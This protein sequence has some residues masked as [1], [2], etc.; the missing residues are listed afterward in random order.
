MSLSH[1]NYSSALLFCSQSAAVAAAAVSSCWISPG[2]GA[3]IR[4]CCPAGQ[5][6]QQNAKAGCCISGAPICCPQGWQPCGA[7]LAFS[8]SSWCCCSSPQASFWPGCPPHHLQV[9]RAP[10]IYTSHNFPVPSFYL[11]FLFLC[12]SLL[13]SLPSSAVLL[14]WNQASPT[15]CS[16]LTK[17][18]SNLSELIGQGL[19][20]GAHLVYEVSCPSKTHLNPPLV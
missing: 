7:R 8:S 12:Y 16:L 5:Q 6:Q 3:V 19:E 15:G 1:C 18:D 9:Q 4:G 10:L 20:I 11:L 14:S 2:G 13:F 17:Q